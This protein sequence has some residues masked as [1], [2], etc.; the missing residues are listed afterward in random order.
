LIDERR[1]IQQRLAEKKAARRR[2]QTVLLRTL[3]R[4]V[5]PA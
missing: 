3:V 1:A 2:G 5:S 4:L